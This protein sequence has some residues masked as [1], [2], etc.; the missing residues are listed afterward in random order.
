MFTCYPKDKKVKIEE[1]DNGE[2][3]KEYK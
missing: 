2:L 3:I 1:Y